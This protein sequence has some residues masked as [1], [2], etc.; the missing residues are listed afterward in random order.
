[1]KNP[2]WNRKS[3]IS[4]EIRGVFHNYEYKL[5]QLHRLNPETEFQADW[6][7]FIFVP[8]FKLYLEFRKYQYLN[9]VKLSLLIGLSYSWKF[10]CLVILSPITRVLLQYISLQPFK[11]FRNFWV[12]DFFGKWHHPINSSLETKRTLKLTWTL[13]SNTKKLQGIKWHKPQNWILTRFGVM[14]R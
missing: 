2:Y 5:L 13:L 4:L 9:H 3:A 12:I 1:M 10:V 7:N 14:S 11:F 8:Y 6:I